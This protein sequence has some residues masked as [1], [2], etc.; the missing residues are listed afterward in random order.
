MHTTSV[1]F[2]GFT[3]DTDLPQHIHEHI[4]RLSR[5]TDQ[6]T[7]VRVAVSLPHRHRSS[8]RIF[9]VHIRAHVPGTEIVVDRET[10]HDPRHADVDVAVHD[11]FATLERQLSSWADRQRPRRIRA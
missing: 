6:V 5:F 10:E 2:H 3:P 9:H 11:A 8:G 1:H 7:G 4:Q